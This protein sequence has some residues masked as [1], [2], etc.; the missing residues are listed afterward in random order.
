[1]ST[2]TGYNPAD[3]PPGLVAIPATDWMYTKAVQALL[4]GLIQA[5]PPYSSIDINPQISSPA[6]N[7]NF[8]VERFLARPDFTWLCFLDSDMTP[9]P[10]TV[11]RLVSHNKDIVGATCFS[12]SGEYLDTYNDLSGEQAE[13]NDDGLREVASVGFGCV[14]VR[15]AVLAAMTQ[16]FF[17]TDSP[18]ALG[19]DVGFCVKAR[20]LGFRVYLDTRLVVGH[21]HVL[22]IDEQNVTALRQQ[23]RVK[24]LEKLARVGR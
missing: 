17:S 6:A 12:R 23:P 22:P 9:P 11:V 19:E 8:L 13:T 18:F 1:M 21:L 3:Y 7:R 10:A 15:R 20:Q 2:P 5:L 14:L 24:E 16:P 4:M